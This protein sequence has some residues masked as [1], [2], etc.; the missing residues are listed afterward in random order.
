MSGIVTFFLQIVTKFG[1]NQDQVREV[2]E[3]KKKLT[4]TRDK[5]AYISMRIK[6]RPRMNVEG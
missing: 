1:G 2:L 3:L 5:Y 4:T 6:F